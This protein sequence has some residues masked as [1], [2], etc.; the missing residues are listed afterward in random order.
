M[1][2]ILVQEGFV[3][4]L[5]QHSKTE[6]AYTIAR[7]ISVAK[8][9]IQIYNAGGAHSN[10]SVYKSDAKS[11]AKAKVK[12]LLWINARLA[13]RG[14]KTVSSWTGFNNLV[15]NE[16]LVVQDLSMINAPATSISTTHE[17][18]YQTRQ[19]KVSPDI[20][21]I[22]MTLYIPKLLRLLRSIQMNLSRQYCVWKPSIPSVL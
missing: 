6:I 22:A 5:Q 4:P 10:G 14:L 19:I 2:G 17:M 20:S 7:S 1:N 18:L 21:N 16:T 11:V 3:S 13:H 8:T 15:H 9:E 12:N